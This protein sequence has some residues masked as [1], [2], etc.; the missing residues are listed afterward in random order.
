MLTK[1][2][3]LTVAAILLGASLPSPA[4]G[5]GTTAAN[6]LLIGNGGR[7]VAMG[8]ASRAS[9]NDATA[10]YW[11]PA[12]LTEVDKRSIY[13]SNRFGGMGMHQ[14]YFGAALPISQGVA[15]IAATYF[16]AGGIDG[17][18]ENAVSTGEFKASDIIVS[19]AFSKRLKKFFNVGVAAGALFDSIDDSKENAFMA[20]L[21][22][23]VDVPDTVN[24]M[25]KALDVPDNLK[26]ALVVGNIGSSL[27]NDDLPAIYSFGAAWQRERLIVEADITGVKDGGAHFSAGFEYLFDR[28]AP[29]AGFNSRTDAGS[30]LRVGIGIFLMD[31]IIDYAY[32]PGGDIS[33][34]HY[35]GVVLHR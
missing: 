2:I 10:I 16:T 5:A 17:M 30:G 18:D 24:L 31:L 23:S 27:G 19:G 22:V 33:D 13:L 12:Q 14:G 35:L 11:N 25:G 26:L 7:A 4:C 21:G 28:F 8:D 20:T 32:V 1:L 29:R 34:S 3:S 15:G 9:A 6:F